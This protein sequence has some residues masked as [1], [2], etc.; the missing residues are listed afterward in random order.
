MTSFTIDLLDASNNPIGDGPLQNVL[1]VSAQEKLDEAGTV[2][3]TVPATDYRAATL[4]SQADRFRVRLSSGAFIYGIIEK[5]T[6]D[7]AVDQPTRTIVGSDMLRELQHYTMGWWCFYANS[8]LNTVILPELVAGTG[9]TLGTVDAALG[10]LYYRFDGDSRLAALIKIASNTGKHFRLGSAFRSIDFGA[11][12][13]SSG[14][15]F[16]N[17]PDG[18]PAWDGTPIIKSLQ[19]IS[20]RG[21]IVNRIIP[22]GAGQD[23]GDTNRA[24]VSLFHLQ[25]TDSRWNNIKCKP[26]VRGAQATVTAVGA[27]GKQYIT[28]ETDGFFDNPITQLFWC[29]DPQNLQLGRGYDFVVDEVTAGVDILTRGS[30]T[31]PAEPTSFPVELISNPQLYI[32]D[33]TAYAEDPHEAVIIFSDVT[34]TNLSLGAFESAASQLYY[35][36]AQYLATHKVPQIAYAV[37]VFNCP[38]DLH[39]GDLVHITY[40]GTLRRGGVEYDW[41]DVDTDLFVINITRQFNADGSTAA[42]VEVS[43]LQRQP[44]DS[45]TAMADSTGMVGAHAVTVGAPSASSAEGGGGGSG[46]AGDLLTFALPLWREV[47]NV[48]LPLTSAH[49]FVGSALNVPAD[50]ALS[51]DATLANTGALTLATVNSNVGS[52]TAAN[53]TVNA[54]GLITAVANGASGMAV[55]DNIVTVAKSGSD[56]T[57]LAAALAAI[58]D[59]SSTNRYGVVIMPGIYDEFDLELKDCVDIMALVPGTV[60]FK[61]T[62]FPSGYGIF[63]RMDGSLSTGVNVTGIDFELSSGYNKYCLIL[64]YAGALNATF[65]HCRFTVSGGSVTYPAGVSYHTSGLVL[66]E[67]CIFANNVAATTYEALGCAA[68][69]GSVVVSKCRLTTNS[70]ATGSKAINVEGSGL[71]VYHCE[72][73]GGEYSL[74]VQYSAATVYVALTRMTADIGP[75]V[76]NA[77]PFPHN[78]T[79]LARPTTSI[80]GATIVYNSGQAVNIATTFDGYTLAQVVRALRDLGLLT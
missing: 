50:V 63:S 70:T 21:P 51:G 41:V 7:A 57:T 48:T 2:S 67:N 72:L 64:S 69:G 43:N 56:Y 32:E 28:T 71:S 29:Y 27:D 47:N 37:S 77:I 1:S 19:V 38:D 66:F 20:D 49:V 73:H 59:A 74:A 52:F 60:L 3:F 30:P 25:S 9:W 16:Q 46:G 8:N 68:D 75:S 33:A 40:S 39:V 15:T 65:R 24:K 55:Y 17:V 11:F 13:V 80:G 22:W 44:I 4:I 26:G 61:P 79:A 31:V 18:R 36:A 35:R 54:K 78:A 34:L 45:T 62:T 58:T 76:T 5:D 12:G 53:I 23:G 6:L 42:T 10:T 14:V